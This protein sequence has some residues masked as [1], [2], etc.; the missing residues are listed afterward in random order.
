M[1]MRNER[2]A[3]SR[4]SRRSALGLICGAAASP[5]ILS[6]RAEAPYPN[7]P[8]SLYVPGL[9]GGA[10]DFMARPVSEHM[11]RTLGQAVVLDHKPGG[12]FAIA[13]AA[14]AAAKPDG[15]SLSIVVSNIGRVSLMQRLPFDPLADLTYILQ[16]CDVAVGI[17]ARADL[18]FKTIPEMVAYARDNPGKV[19]YGSPGAGSAAH[20]GMEQLAGKAG[21]KLTHVPF[22][23]MQEAI[24]AILG[25][26]IMLLV[27]ALEWK[28]HVE[29]GE[30]RVLAM[31]TNERRSIWPDVPTLSEVGFASPLSLASFAI[32]GPKGL[33]APIVARLHDAIKSAIDDA[34]VKAALVSRELLPSYRSGADFRRHVEAMLPLEREVVTALGLG[35]K[36]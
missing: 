22:R 17:A 35:R 8:I 4:F 19:T 14:V 13:P 20:V 36:D 2:I 30:L 26:H 10:F 34:A 25:K 18:P 16:V 32:A 24:P 15:Y 27:S 31:L 7:R 33:P 5:Y 28:Q 11:A 9:P 21:I 12:G 3:A 29:T 23:G 6:A 1:N